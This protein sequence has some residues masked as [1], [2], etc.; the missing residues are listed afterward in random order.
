MSVVMSGFSLVEQAA[1]SGLMKM[2]LGELQLIQEL[3]GN[4]CIIMGRS[5]KLET[6]HGIIR[7]MK[8]LKA[9]SN[10]MRIAEEEHLAEMQRQEE[11]EEMQRQEERQKV[12]VTAAVAIQAWGV[13]IKAIK[14]AK[15]KGE[16]QWQQAQNF[17]EQQEEQNK[18]QQ[19][20]YFVFFCFF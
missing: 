16:Q 8:K 5:R 10:I 4:S 17:F 19:A 15:I 13:A 6:A 2:T 1:I 14:A 11:E 9:D 20:F 3:L 7:T 12:R 18:E